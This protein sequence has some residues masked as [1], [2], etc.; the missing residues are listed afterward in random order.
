MTLFS[1]EVPIE[2]LALISKSVMDK[3]IKLLL[4]FE[5][6]IVKKKL[7]VTPILE[8]FFRILM[9]FLKY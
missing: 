3:N 7:K 6:S 1:Q 8:F 2:I 9:F 4:S 5:L